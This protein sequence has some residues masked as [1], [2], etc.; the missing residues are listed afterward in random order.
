[1][2]Y[3]NSMNKREFT[4]VYQKKGRWVVAWVEEIPGV[5]TQGRTFKEAKENLL[6]A[7]RLIVEL[8]RSLAAGKN[9]GARRESLQIA[10]P[11]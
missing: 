2:W 1:M 5:N 6:E 3:R 8:N 9:T 4:A 10:L 7:L 11:A